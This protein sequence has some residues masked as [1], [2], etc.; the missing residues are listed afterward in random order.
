MELLGLLSLVFLLAE[1]PLGP[2]VYALEGA[3]VHVGTGD[4][5]DG[6][7]VVIEDGLIVDVGPSAS[8]TPPEG[9]W[10]I[11]ASDKHVYPGFVDALSDLG[12]KKRAD[13]KG[14]GNGNGDGDGGEGERSFASGPEDRPA[15]TTWRSA[16]DEVS[17]GDDR[18]ESWRNAGFTSAVAAPEEG[19]FPGQAA[20]INLDGSRDNELVVAAPVSIVVDLSPPSGGR[21]Y[22]GS[23]M[24]V[25]AYVEQ[26][27]LDA[28][29]YRESL[30]IYEASPLGKKRPTYDRA[31]EPLVS[32][33]TQGTPVLFPATRE[34]EIE[35]AIELAKELSLRPVLYGGH[36]GYAA[37]ERLREENVPLLVNLKWPERGKDVDPEAEASLRVLR[38]REHAPETPGVLEAAGVRFALYS[39]D[40]AKSEEAIAAVRRA[41]EAGLSSEGAVQALSLSPAVIFGVDDRTGSVEKGKI[42][43]LFIA[44]GDVFA[45]G[46]RVQTVFVDGVKHEVRAP[47]AADTEEEGASR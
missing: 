47:S 7:T 9:A 34:H 36:E 29:H 30:R 31:L 25:I 1:D 8:V 27:F 2:S 37:A 22:P 33:Q 46:S 3:R 26:T 16:A 39:G 43:N 17:L 18:L 24:G 5:I 41:I 21:S 10:V 19:I 35:R 44:D 28:A 4:V 15:T 12:M 45:E 23:L 6:A 32:A 13:G 14:N 38:L 42:A 20:F 11:D 40:L